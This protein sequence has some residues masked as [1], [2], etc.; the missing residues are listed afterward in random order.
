MGEAMARAYL[1]LG[2]NMGDREANI[3]RAIEELG[4]QGVRVTRES[5][6]YETEPVEYREQ[7]WFLNCVVE[8]ETN[9]EPLEVLSAALEIERGMGR[10]R[11][12]PKG[13]R[14]I[15]IDILF[16]D[17]AVIDAGELQVPHPRLTERRFVLVPLTEIAPGLI[18]PVRKKT[19]TQLLAETKD[20]S[21]VR[22]AGH[23]G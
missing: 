12:V 16:Y 22:R 10:E 21:E 23:G 13:P 19:V 3:A 15:D 1:S 5:S 7:N 6:L 14:V 2:T 18:H 11:R 17:E 9:L 4:E 20:D 8:A